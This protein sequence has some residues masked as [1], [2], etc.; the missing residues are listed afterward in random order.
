MQ[1]HLVLYEYLSY[2]VN[3]AVIQDINTLQCTGVRMLDME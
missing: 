2:T 3:V 1:T